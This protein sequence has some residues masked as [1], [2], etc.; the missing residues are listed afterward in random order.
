MTTVEPVPRRVFVVWFGPPMNENR[1]AGLRSIQ[2][3]VGVDVV[4]I[5]ENSLEDWIDPDIPLHPA[6]HLLTA[7]QKSDYLRCYL[8]HVHGGGYADMKPQ[9]GSWVPVFDEM[10]CTPEAF[11]SG[12]TE[13]NRSGVAQLGLPLSRKWE[14]RPFER[15]W[16]RYRWLQFNYRRVV[17]NC[18]LVFRSKTPFTAR[19][20][21]QLTAVMDRNA[22]AL[23]MNP[24][25]HPKERS[26]A[27]YDG[28]VSLYPIHWGGLMADIFQ[29]LCLR[30]R[31]RILHGI[32]TPVF[33]DYQ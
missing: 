10:D 16:W 18:A 29:P 2:E 3:T 22:Y 27:V 1:L 4:V 7:V 31:H 13:I 15:N 30:H 23:A 32:P 8:L 21:E 26:G 11:G 9:S 12:Y 24:G 19:W 25:R 33:S 28:K 6:F 14:L 20:F 5:D 17:G